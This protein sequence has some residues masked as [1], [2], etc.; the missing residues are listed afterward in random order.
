M[1]GRD[2]KNDLSAGI[3]FFPSHDLIPERCEIGEFQNSRVL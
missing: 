2:I 1:D 3:K